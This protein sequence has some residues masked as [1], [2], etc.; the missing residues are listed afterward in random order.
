[1]QVG[2]KSSR[3]DA[4]SIKT[5]ASANLENKTDANRICHTPIM[6]S[7]KKST[8]KPKRTALTKIHVVVIVPEQSTVTR[9]HRL[10]E[11]HH[12]IRFLPLVCTPFDIGVRAG[13]LRLA[14]GDH[15]QLNMCASKSVRWRSMSEHFSLNYRQQKGQT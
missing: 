8:R 2:K 10:V 3:K 14:L 1:M 5:K 6:A 7:N 12:S 13:G 11:N 9:Q 15:A 4:N